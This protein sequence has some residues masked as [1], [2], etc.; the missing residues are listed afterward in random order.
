MAFSGN[1]KLLAS[2]S[3]DGI[4]RIYAMMDGEAP[5]L[6]HILV[7]ARDSI[8]KDD[9]DGR[10][11]KGDCRVRTVAFSADSKL[12]ASGALDGKVRLFSL[13]PEPGPSSDVVVV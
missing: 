3:L 1:S 12:L 13:F 6:K 9:D 10:T 5:W 4:V 8:G 7:D 11:N 2:S